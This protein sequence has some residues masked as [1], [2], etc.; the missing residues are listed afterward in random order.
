MFSKRKSL[1]PQFVIPCQICAGLMKHAGTMAGKFGSPE[2]HRFE[3]D[4]CGA[5]C[6]IELKA[7]LK[8]AA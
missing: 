7:K 6:S 3:C 2:M 1:T 8:A 5:L 4:A